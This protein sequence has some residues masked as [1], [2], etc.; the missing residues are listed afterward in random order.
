MKKYKVQIKGDRKTSI[1]LKEDEPVEVESPVEGDA[2]LE[3]AYRYLLKDAKASGVPSN[4][5]ELLIMSVI[6]LFNA[7][8]DSK[9]NTS[10]E[11]L[12]NR[13]LKLVYQRIVK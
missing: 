13:A 3:Y 10:V 9:F 8:K 11:T 6:N 4:R 7:L 5:A 12:L 2:N 1:K